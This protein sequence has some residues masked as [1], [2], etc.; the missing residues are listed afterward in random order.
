MSD[1]ND[2]RQW[3]ENVSHLVHAHGGD[4][5]RLIAFAPTLEQLSF[6]HSDTHAALALIGTRPPD[7]HAHT[8]PLDPGHPEPRPASYRPFPP[9]PE[10]GHRRYSRDPSLFPSPRQTGLP[11]TGDRP[12]DEHSTT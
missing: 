7:G 5:D 12:L 9:A 11:H 6:A 3:H 2:A 8:A 10:A 4:Q 1:L